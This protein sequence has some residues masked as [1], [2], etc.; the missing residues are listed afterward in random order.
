MKTT[1]RGTWGNNEDQR[2]GNPSVHL[3]L[4][5]LS[6]TSLRTSFWSPAILPLSL[7]CLWASNDPHSSTPL[8][9]CSHP[10]PTSKLPPLDSAQTPVL[11]NQCWHLRESWGLLF[12]LPEGFVCAPV[13]TSHRN[14]F[15]FFVN[16]RRCQSNVCFSGFN[17]QE[18]KH[19][20][21][22]VKT[23]HY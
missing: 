23:S 18:Y 20:P 17:F 21:W 7:P 14:I 19:L 5:R 3:H 9:S 11:W 13:S 12:V 4:P 6:F 16:L 1:P 8:F 10:F 15:W 22:R 2:L